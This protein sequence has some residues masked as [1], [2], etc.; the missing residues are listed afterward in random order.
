MSGRVETLAWLI[1][2]YGDVT[3]AQAIELLRLE[4]RVELEGGTCDRC[5]AVDDEPCSEG[6]RCDEC[7][8]DDPDDFP[9]WAVWE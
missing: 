9:G 5:G 1:A 6:C 7:R 3:V 2:R 4:L 8:T